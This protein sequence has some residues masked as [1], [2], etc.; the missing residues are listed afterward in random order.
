MSFSPTDK[1]RDD[2]SAIPTPPLSSRF[3]LSRPQLPQMQTPLC[4]CTQTRGH[5]VSDL[6]SSLNFSRVKRDKLALSELVK[7][8]AL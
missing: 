5:A 3:L 4:M 7:D 6:Q 2:T 8:L 1:T